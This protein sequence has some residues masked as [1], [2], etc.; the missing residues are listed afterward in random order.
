M[1]NQDNQPKGSYTPTSGNTSGVN[2]AQPKGPYG[3]RMMPLPQMTS[4]PMQGMSGGNASPSGV[5]HISNGPAAP[6][7]EVSWPAVP[8]AQQSAPA[9]PDPQRKSRV[10]R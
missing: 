1:A 7:T 10:Q 9:Q 2:D 8:L 3:S 6:V 5:Q 4:G